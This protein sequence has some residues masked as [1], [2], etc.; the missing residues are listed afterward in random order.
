MTDDETTRDDE[1]ALLRQGLVLPGAV[2]QVR[3]HDGQIGLDVS[4]LEPWR[5]I[6][7]H[8]LLDEVHPPLLR[9]AAHQVV[10]SLEDEAPAQVRQT[11]EI[12]PCLL[13]LV[14]K[15]W[16]GN[17]CAPGAPDFLQSILQFLCKSW[18]DPANQTLNN[19]ILDDLK[20][21]ILQYPQ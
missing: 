12:G 19:Q 9:E 13:H 15:G 2:G 18:A 8:R 14:S 7:E 1:T 10:R 5:T 17:L 20:A 11:D 6:L 4:R 21:K 16:I 3:H